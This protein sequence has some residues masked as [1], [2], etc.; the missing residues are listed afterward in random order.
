MRRVAAKL[1]KVKHG[2]G[3][4]IEATTYS[5]DQSPSMVI[6]GHFTCRSKTPEQNSA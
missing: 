5:A 3:T 1:S 6:K 4:R 2:K